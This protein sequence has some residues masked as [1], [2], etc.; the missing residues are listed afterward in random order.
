[1]HTSL[2][3]PCSCK[4]MSS[5]TSTT[6]SQHL[7]I[8]PQT[9]SLFCMSIHQGRELLKN[10]EKK[11]ITGS[12]VRMLPW[13]HSRQDTALMLDAKEYE[14]TMGISLFPY[15]QTTHLPLPTVIKQSPHKPAD[16]T[17]CWKNLVPETQLD[18]LIPIE[19]NC[20]T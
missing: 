8:P 2:D 17:T 7:H 19:T 11:K 13:L 9:R 4:F 16:I 10:L 15:C 6:V 3:L 5:Q 18:R 20:N 12:D 14:L 1:M